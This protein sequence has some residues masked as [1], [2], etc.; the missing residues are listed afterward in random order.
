MPPV[1]SQIYATEG[2]N[3]TRKI[4]K[5]NITQ[6]DGKRSEKRIQKINKT[7]IALQFTSL[8]TSLLLSE[9]KYLEY[10]E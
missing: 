5:K 4:E 9:R 6:K 2:Q 10:C 3:V 7:K 1:R 8:L